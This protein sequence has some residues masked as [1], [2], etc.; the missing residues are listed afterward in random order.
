MDVKYRLKG[1]S[2]RTDHWEQDQAMKMLSLEYQTLRDEMIMRMSSR[3][4]FLGF[5]TTAAA[6]LATIIGHS[7]LGYQ[8]WLI[9]GLAAGTFILGFACFWLL[10]RHIIY[11]SARVA[12]IE[13]RINDL[14]PGNPNLLTWESE[15]Q[16][17]GYSQW[18]R[19]VQLGPGR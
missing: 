9:V 4:Q 17:H 15:H 3:F 2:N 18:R 5:T 1:R 13:K 16:Q 8:T 12:H 10:G 6:L 14:L 7:S 19:G 11:M